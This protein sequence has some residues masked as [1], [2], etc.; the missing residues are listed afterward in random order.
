MYQGYAKT[1]NGLTRPSHETII[2][3]ARASR[4]IAASP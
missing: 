4:V 2:E 1:V 3:S